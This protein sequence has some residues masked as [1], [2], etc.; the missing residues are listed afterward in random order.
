MTFTA[1]FEDLVFCESVARAVLVA[2][3]DATVNAVVFAEIANLDKS[4]DVYGIA[5]YFF[6]RINGVRREKLC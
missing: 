4:S 2:S 1:A 6:S 5:V 3:Y